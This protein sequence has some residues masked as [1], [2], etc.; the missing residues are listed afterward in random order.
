MSYCRFENTSR[1]LRDC[2]NAINNGE[3]TELSDYEAEGLED[4]LELAK[5]LLELKSE[6]TW[7][8]DLHKSEFGFERGY[9]E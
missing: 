2:I 4:L 8:L 6:I 3:T 7:A 5:E 1:D 9:D